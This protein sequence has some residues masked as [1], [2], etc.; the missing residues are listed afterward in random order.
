MSQNRQARTRTG[1]TAGNDFKV[2]FENLKYYQEDIHDKTRQNFC[3]S[4][5]ICR[6]RMD[7]LEE[8]KRRKKSW[9]ILKY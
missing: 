1:K 6:K 7:N 3:H 5:L 2:K 8:K 4:K 9:N